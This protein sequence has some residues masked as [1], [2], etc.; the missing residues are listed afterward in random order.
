M[1]ASRSP[2]PDGAAAA[3]WFTERELP[4]GHPGVRVS[5]QV[6]RVLHDE[7]S[8][9]GH[10]QVLDTP[11]HGRVLVIDGIVQTTEHDEFVYHEM[12]VL[13][14]GV[15]H[16]RPASMLIVGGGDGGALRQALRLRSLR[17]V[18]QVEI[19]DTVSRVCR[20][21]LP[22]VSGGAFDDPRVELVWADGARYLAACRRRFDVIVLDLTDPVPGGPAESLFGERFLRT[23]A[24]ALAPGGVLA[25]QCGSLTLQP[26]EVRTQLRLTRRLFPDTT[27][28]TAVVPGYQLT[29]FGFLLAGGDP[30]DLGDPAGRWANIDGPCRYLSPQMYAASTVLPPY[31]RQILDRE[32]NLRGAC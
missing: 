29:S 22:R 9:F 11:F 6:H 1:T 17:S 28:H 20:E 3:H 15:R 16:G 27:L 30:P 12:L 2:E 5:F 24:D 19:D 32:T 23:A 4:Y 14:A 31:L 7:R 21:H 25:A 13:G 8:P 26:D 18:V 10:I